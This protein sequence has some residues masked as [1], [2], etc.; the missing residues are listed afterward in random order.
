MLDA[1]GAAAIQ[2]ALQRLVLLAGDGPVTLEV[3]ESDPG[4]KKTLAPTAEDLEERFSLT[5]SE[6][7]QIRR[8]LEASRGNRDAAAKLLGVS[9]ATV[10]RK[11][12][13]Y[14]IR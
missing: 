14:K 9:R 6:R 1:W 5:R 13:E 2:N 3:L 7:E 12:K 10:Y 8:A 11:L 4:L